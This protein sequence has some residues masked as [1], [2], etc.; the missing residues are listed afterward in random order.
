V[1]EYQS[2]INAGW[3][4]SMGMENLMISRLIWTTWK[5]NGIGEELVFIFEDCFGT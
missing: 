5:E 3:K 1:N 2:D 4:I